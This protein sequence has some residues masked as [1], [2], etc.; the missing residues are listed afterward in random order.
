VVGGSGGQLRRPRLARTLA[1]L[2]KDPRD[3]VARSHAEQDLA[4]DAEHRDV[5]AGKAIHGAA[6]GA[7]LEAEGPAA[8]SGLEAARI[9]VPR[10]HRERVA[11]AHA[12]AG[13]GEQPGEP[14]G[15]GV[16]RG[17]GVVLDWEDG[18]R[19]Q[20]DELRPA[21]ARLGEQRDRRI[22][23]AAARGRAREHGA[24]RERL[25][26]GFAQ[27]A[28]V[29]ADLAHARGRAVEPTRDLL[30]EAAQGRVQTGGGRIQD[31][32][33]AEPHVVR[34][35]ARDARIVSELYQP[36]RTTERA[37]LAVQGLDPALQQGAQAEVGPREAGAAGERRGEQPCQRLGR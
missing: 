24:P 5:L 30:P 15:D 37:Q 4:L 33:P 12:V 22:C 20:L 29:E 35:D 23:T 28:H 16:L 14:R 13:H 10:R 6:R 3:R 11:S 9:V 36:E 1:E 27:G 26:H 32:G 8:G 31:Q 7:Q 19:H 34:P 17:A 21:C 25:G 2:R 18:A